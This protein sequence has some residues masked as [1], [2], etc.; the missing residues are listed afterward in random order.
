MPEVKPEDVLKLL[1][2]LRA[3]GFRCRGL[4]AGAFE[5]ELD[6][7]VI[8]RDTAPEVRLARDIHERWAHDL[9]V[10]MPAD[11]DDDEELTS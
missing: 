3:N 4:K 7:T 9:G 6:D 2:Q 1:L 8:D 10:P 11:D 5:L